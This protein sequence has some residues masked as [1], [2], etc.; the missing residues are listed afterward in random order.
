MMLLLEVVRPCD[1]VNDAPAADTH[2]LL[3]A[4][5]FQMDVIYMVTFHHSFFYVC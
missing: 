2:S 5:H 4:Q 1:S 3:E